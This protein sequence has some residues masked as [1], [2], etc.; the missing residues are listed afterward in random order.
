M[1]NSKKRKGTND[2]F[3][4]AV[5]KCS[6]IKD[7]LKPGLM[8]LKANSKV[9]RPANTKLIDGSVDIDEA[10]KDLHPQESRWD[11]V[12]GYEKKFSL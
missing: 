10:V 2:S 1:G 4:D 3:A 5:S 11:Y 7:A 8:A 12:V 9:V 6:E